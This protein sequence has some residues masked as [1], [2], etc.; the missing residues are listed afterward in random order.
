MSH[1]NIIIIS[2]DHRDL[3]SQNKISLYT[4]LPRHLDLAKNLKKKHHEQ[5]RRILL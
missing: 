5:I 2:D 4:L 1:H 3:I